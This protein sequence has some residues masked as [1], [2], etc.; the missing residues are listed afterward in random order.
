MIR[1]G[2]VAALAFASIPES[3]PHVQYV[4]II[5][6]RK[7]GDARRKV[8]VPRHEKPVLKFYKRNRAFSEHV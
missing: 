8:C 3:T 5:K 6:S 2:V 4:A 7:Q 1:D